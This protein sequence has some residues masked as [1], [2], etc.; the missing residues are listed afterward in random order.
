M[1][2][3]VVSDTRTYNLVLEETVNR[4]VVRIQTELFKPG[5]KVRGHLIDIYTR[6]PNHCTWY[7]KQPQMKFV[8]DPEGVHAA[9]GHPGKMLVF[10][11]GGLFFTFHALGAQVDGYTTGDID[12]LMKEIPAKNLFA[13]DLGHFADLAMMSLNM[14]SNNAMWAV[15][16]VYDVDAENVRVQFEATL[17]LD[18]VPLDELVELAQAAEDEKRQDDTRAA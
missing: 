16:A 1:R 11:E 8:D 10:E 7:P 3:L 18:E 2:S 9:Y 17:E 13:E 4:N 12:F 15:L 5:E 14:F 6:P